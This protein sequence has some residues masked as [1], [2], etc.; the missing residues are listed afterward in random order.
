MTDAS[1]THYSYTLNGTLYGLLHACKSNAKQRL[2][3]GRT[4]AG[5]FDLEL[6]DLYN[7]WEEQN[8]KCY[9]SGIPMNYDRNEWRISVDRLN[10]NKGYTIDNI[11]L[12]CLEFNGREQWT[13]SKIHEMLAILDKNVTENYVDFKQNGKSDLLPVNQLRRLISSSKKS[14]EHRKQTITFAQRDLTHDI[15][16]QFLINIYNEQ[17]GLCYYSDLPLQFNKGLNGNWTISLER[18][19]PLK[20]YS[21]Q[22]VC[23]ICLE[24]NTFDHSVLQLTTESGSCGWSP[25]KFKLF[26][27]YLWLKKGFIHSEDELQIFFDMQKTTM[28]REDH[29]YVPNPF[30][31]VTGINRLRFMRDI[32]Q[33]KKLYGQIIL[34]TAPNNKQYVLK[35]DVVDRSIKNVFKHI[36]NTG[37]KLIIDAIEEYGKDKFKLEPI[38][39]CKL[40]VLDDLHQYFIKEYNAELNE[41]V[42]FQH[43]E[44]TRSQISDSLIEKGM[45]NRK[46]HQGRTLPKYMKFNNWADRKGYMIVSHPKCKK[47]SFSDNKKTLD[48]L[49]NECLKFLETLN[50]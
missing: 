35:L 20:G 21:K 8:G 6:D 19:D 39:T 34:I 7:I 46:D 41:I 2:D 44:E 48:E 45:Q 4:D 13:I 31:T 1:N 15:D 42:R 25:E 12:C 38:V 10:N 27:G 17:K 43:T 16:L 18:K 3:K 14:T 28:S 36:K 40:D 30:K 33:K 29:N 50:A 22:N 23:L 37:H 5:V 9:H 32:I 49:Y 24:F 26:L 11:V 47:K